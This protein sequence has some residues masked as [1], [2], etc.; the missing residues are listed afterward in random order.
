MTGCHT[1]RATIA[2]AATAMRTTAVPAAPAVLPERHT[3]VAGSTVMIPAVVHATVVVARAPHAVP[4][5]ARHPVATVP[6]AGKASIGMCRVEDVPKERNVAL[7]ARGTETVDGVPVTG[8]ETTNVNAEGLRGAWS[9]IAGIL[10]KTRMIPKTRTGIGTVIESDEDG[11]VLRT[12]EAV[13]GRV[14]RRAETA[15]TPAEYQV[16]VKRIGPGTGTQIQAHGLTLLRVA[17]IVHVGVR[18]LKNENMVVRRY[19]PCCRQLVPLDPKKLL[20][21]LPG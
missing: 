9:L 10:V 19:I 7:L 14:V 8:F 21:L 20:G 12:A 15:M 5:T 1:A 11:V 18:K 17:Q 13:D 4:A 3:P 16:T 6:V 2:D